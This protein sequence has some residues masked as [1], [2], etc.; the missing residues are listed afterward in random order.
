MGAASAFGLPGAFGAWD[1]PFG[2]LPVPSVPL[3]A[4]GRGTMKRAPSSYL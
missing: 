3:Q 2:L 4:E 1:S